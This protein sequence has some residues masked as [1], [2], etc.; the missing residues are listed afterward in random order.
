MACLRFP[1]I[2][3]IFRKKPL[4]KGKPDDIIK[5]KA[6]PRAR[7]KESIMEEKSVEKAVDKAEKNG[8]TKGWTI[9]AVILS[10][11]ISISGIVMALCCSP[12]DRDDAK[13]IQATFS[14][15]KMKY[16]SSGKNYSERITLKF[17]DYEDMT[18]DNFGN[19]QRDIGRLQSGD[20]LII[21]VHPR[22]GD[23]LEITRGGSEIVSYNDAA[24]H[25]IKS[26]IKCIA[27]GIFSFGLG[28]YF[29]CGLAKIIRAEKAKKAKEERKSPD[30]AW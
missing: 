16:E 14:S 12:V 25:L 30:N 6:M 7:R 26:E 22:G 5:G 19:V 4:I 20:R 18:I 23:I 2:M 8:L 21:R 24:R 27:A 13:V 9:A 28:I 1:K 11:F 10:F 3:R 29:A 17:S 15:Y